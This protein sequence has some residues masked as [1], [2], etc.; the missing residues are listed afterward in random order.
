MEGE[1]E[2]KGNR[3]WWGGGGGGDRKKQD[4][5]K[6]ESKRLRNEGKLDLVFATPNFNIHFWHL[7]CK[8][9]RKGCDQVG[10]SQNVHAVIGQS[11]IMKIMMSHCSKL[12]HML[13]Y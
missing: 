8:T 6:R 3:E 5:R 2:I 11:I 10:F 1:R 13:Y 12:G 7:A 4:K 9:H